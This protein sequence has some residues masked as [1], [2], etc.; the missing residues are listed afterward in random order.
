[1]PLLSIG[2]WT[3]IGFNINGFPN[4]N[5]YNYTVSLSSDGVIV[6]IGEPY[7]NGNSLGSGKVRVFKNNLGVWTQI[8]QDIDGEADIDYSGLSEY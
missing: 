5:D 4:N 8:G 2:Q 6:A 1:M 3:Q 7:C